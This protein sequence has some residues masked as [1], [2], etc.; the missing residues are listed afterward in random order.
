[1]SDIAELKSDSSELKEL[2]EVAKRP[3]VKDVLKNELASV[4]SK[5]GEIESKRAKEEEKAA[6]AETKEGLGI[7]E[8]PNS[9]PKAAIKPTKEAKVQRTKI[10]GYDY[11][12]RNN[13][14][15]G[16]FPCQAIGCSYVCRWQCEMKVHMNKH[17]KEKPFL[18]DWANCGKS[19]GDKSSMRT[20]YNAVH[21]KLKKFKCHVK[22]CSLSFTCAKSRNR[23]S[24]NVKLHEKLFSGQY[25]RD[26]YMCVNHTNVPKEE[27]VSKM[28]E[29]FDGDHP[30]VEEK[31]PEEEKVPSPGADYDKFYLDHPKMANPM[32]M[33]FLNNQ[34]MFP[35]AADYF[36]YKDLVSN[37]LMKEVGYNVYGLNYGFGT[38]GCHSLFLPPR[39]SVIKENTYKVGKLSPLT[40]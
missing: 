3:R 9:K 18:C 4:E 11:S 38:A 40:I 6:T 34:A 17:T 14:K 22:G 8:D 39:A 7:T 5:I 12:L 26:Q 21:L 13:S 23:H 24:R 31:L 32:G 37:A 30:M 25:F 1:M 20:H 16:R 19:F 28:E 33:M 15:E 36:L 29:D 2:L 10:T 27:K 35:H